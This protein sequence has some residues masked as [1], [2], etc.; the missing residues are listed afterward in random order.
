MEEQGDGLLRML[1]LVAEAGGDGM[2][3][4]TMEQTEGDGAQ[5]AEDA[6]ALAFVDEAGILPQGHILGPMLPVLDQPM[7]ALEGQEPPGGSD[8]WWQAGD[9]VAHLLVPLLLLPPGPLDAEDLGHPG[10]IGQGQ[11]I[12]RGPQLPQVDP[13]MSL[14]EGPEGTPA[15]WQWSSGRAWGSK[16]RTSSRWSVGWLALT[17][18]R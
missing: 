13:P 5:H 10:P 7:L 15:S 11:R 17:V 16:V 14:V 6:G 18:S 8:L 12:G 3:A 2:V 1:T 9:A 4:G